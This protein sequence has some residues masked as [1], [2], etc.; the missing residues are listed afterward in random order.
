MLRLTLR[1]LAKADRPSRPMK[2]DDRSML[3]TLRLF[4]SACAIATAPLSLIH[5]QMLSYDY[6]WSVNRYPMA[7]TDKSMVVR[8]V[9]MLL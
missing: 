8:D 7:F 1:S 9:L 5:K 6:F 3:F 2:F 4:I